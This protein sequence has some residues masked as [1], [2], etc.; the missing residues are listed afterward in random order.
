MTF[1]NESGGPLVDQ[2]VRFI[3]PQNSGEIIT[4]KTDMNG[5]LIDHLPDGDW[6]V[7][8]DSAETD[9]AVI[10]GVRTTIIVSE[11]TANDAQTIST[12]E[13]ASFTV[14]ISDAD[15]VNLGDMELQLISND[16]LGAVYLDNTDGLGQ[17][18]GVIS[19]GSWNIE[20]NQTLDR[21]QYV[22]DSIELIDGGLVAGENELI[23]SLIHI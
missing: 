1:T 21:T 18:S 4:R 17:T 14:R 19:P 9:T 5:T 6:I 2:L 12:S 3:D 8:I 7:L 16:G 20:L 23:L 22:I 13:L 15:G 10:E 11:Q